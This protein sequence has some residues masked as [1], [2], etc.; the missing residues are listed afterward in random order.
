MYYPLGL[1]RGPAVALVYGPEHAVYRLAD[2]TGCDVLDD[3]GAARDLLDVAAAAPRPD[4]RPVWTV[5]TPDAEQLRV[6]VV[7]R[8]G[9]VPL[10]A[11][12][13]HL[14]VSLPAGW[15]LRNGTTVLVD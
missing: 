9:W 13:A 2:A 4:P 3:P 11:L 14:A 15:S 12:V 5:T 1:V 8:H 7:N 6:D 10:A